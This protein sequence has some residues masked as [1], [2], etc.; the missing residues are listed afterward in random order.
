MKKDRT[1]RERGRRRG[2]GGEGGGRRKGGG[3]RRGGRGT[4]G[5]RRREGGK[6]E[7]EKEA[8]KE[9]EEE[10]VE[11]VDADEGKRVWACLEIFT[12]VKGP[13]DDEDSRVK[14]DKEKRLSHKLT[15]S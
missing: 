7:K 2:G 3:R 14:G 4:D 8:E 12:T 13:N 9:E 1:R 5:G 11:P 6:E 15:N 10:K